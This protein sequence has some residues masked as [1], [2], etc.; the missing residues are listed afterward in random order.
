MLRTTRNVPVPRRLL[1]PTPRRLYPLDTME[2]GEMFFVP[3][4]TTNTLAS[5][6]STVG[7][8]LS[9]KFTTRLCWMRETRKRWVEA[10]QGVEG[11]VLGVGVWRDA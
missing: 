3:G 4:K 6:T 7:R 5:Y 8:K 2:I 9:R 11:A 10:K 1:P